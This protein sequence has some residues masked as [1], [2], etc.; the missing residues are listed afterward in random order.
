MTLRQELIQIMNARLEYP[1]RV[2]VLSN[3]DHRM[4]AAVTVLFR[5]ETFLTSEVLLILRSET[6][7]THK[8]Q[9][10]F[11]GGSV[12]PADQGDLILTALRECEEEV[13]LSRSKIE[14]VGA[15]P[16][17]PT[18]SGNF[19][20]VPVLGTVSAT[21]D[22]TLTLQTQEV[23]I[24]EWVSVKRLLSSRT[25][26]EAQILNVAVKAPEFLWA[27]KRMWGLSAW[28]FDLILNR[29]DTLSS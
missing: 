4:G 20:V 24:A 19:C 28:I 13:G 10:A 27:E 8:G 5:G 26:A 29:Y 11:P 14:V 7:L 12:D 21:Q 17:F 18:L 2:A 23:A 3:S 25:Y 6:V 9:V 22:L 15:L 16:P 1:G